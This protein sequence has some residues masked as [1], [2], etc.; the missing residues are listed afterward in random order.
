MV[1][2]AA[3]VAKCDAKGDLVA[4]EAAAKRFNVFGTPTLVREDGVILKGAPENPAALQAWARGAG[5]S[6]VK[7]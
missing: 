4:I 3:T 7:P 1:A 2:P 5:S 6:K